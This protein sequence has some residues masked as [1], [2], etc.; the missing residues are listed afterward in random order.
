VEFVDHEYL[1]WVLE[2]TE[3]VQPDPVVWDVLWRDEKSTEETQRHD[4]DWHLL[5]SK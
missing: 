4:R 3:I 1:V 5:F 2:E